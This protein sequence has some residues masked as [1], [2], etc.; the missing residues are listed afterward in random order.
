[1]IGE[2]DHNSGQLQGFASTGADLIVHKTLPFMARHVHVEVMIT[3]VDDS[4]HEHVL[5]DQSAPIILE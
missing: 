5:H 2:K 4:R 3:P 1:V